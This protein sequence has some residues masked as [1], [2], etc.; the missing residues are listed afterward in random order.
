M[1]SNPYISV[2]LLGAA[3]LFLTVLFTNT[4]AATI[5][6]IPSPIE[7]YGFN[8]VF[9]G[10]RTDINWQTTSETNNNYFTIERST[11]G[12]NFM[13]LDTV[14]SKVVNGNNAKSMLYTWI[15]SNRVAGVYYYRLKQTDFDFKYTYSNVVVVNITKGADLSFDLTFS[16][17]NKNLIDVFVIAPLSGMMTFKIYDAAGARLHMEDIQVNEGEKNQ[18]ELRLKDPLESGT[19]IVIGILNED[20]TT[21]K[22]MTVSR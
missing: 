9:N 11:D 19:Y 18:F 5:T 7:L 8:A 1:K 13:V 15:D 21:K 10:T 6:A 14:T 3:F 17:D 16:P 2:K 4:F 12:I 20:L 22:L